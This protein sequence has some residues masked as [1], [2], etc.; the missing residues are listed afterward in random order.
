[1]VFFGTKWKKP[2][3]GADSVCTGQLRKHHKLAGYIQ[4]N[5]LGLPCNASLLRDEYSHFHHYIAI[6][7]QNGAYKGS[8]SNNTCNE[9][10]IVKQK[11]K[12]ELEDIAEEVSLDIFTSDLF[13][14]QTE[15]ARRR[16]S[17]NIDIII[18][19]QSMRVYVYH[20]RKV[21]WKY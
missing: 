18:I 20:T 6:D 19:R 8:R 11:A 12:L 1:M 21:F 16:T 10:T 2:H 14:Y 13:G 5:P 4:S 7:I 15:G 17:I 3:S 9:S